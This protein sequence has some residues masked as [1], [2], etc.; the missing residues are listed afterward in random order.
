MGLLLR[1]AGAKYEESGDWH[2]ALEKY[3]EECGGAVID[4][5]DEI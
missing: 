2:E 3:E 4:T 5:D 1:N